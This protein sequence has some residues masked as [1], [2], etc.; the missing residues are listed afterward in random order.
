MI[1]RFVKEKHK[2][3]LAISLNATD[4][5]TEKNYANQ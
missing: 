1:D 5:N 2:Y 3:K 4:D